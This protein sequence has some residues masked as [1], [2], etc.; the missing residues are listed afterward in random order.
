MMHRVCA[1]PDCRTP[2]QPRVY[3]AYPLAKRSRDGGSFT[4]IASPLRRPLCEP[5][6]LVRANPLPPGK[7]DSH[8]CVRRVLAKGDAESAA[9]GE[10]ETGAVAR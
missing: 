9:K 3:E 8:S 1:T 6:Y 2:V 7:D 5:G 10:P 4:V